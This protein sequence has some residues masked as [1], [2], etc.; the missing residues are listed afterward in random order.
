MAA[1]GGMSTTAMVACCMHHLTEILPIL[2]VSAASFFLIKY[3]SFFL[4]IGVGS[5][6]IGIT[7]MLRLIQKQELYEPDHGILGGVLKFDMNRALYINALLGILLAATILIGT[8][9]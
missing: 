4:A 5:N 6:L 3:Q 7:I 9:N 1:A 8:I 2:G